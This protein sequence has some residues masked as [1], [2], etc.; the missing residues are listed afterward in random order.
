VQG[1]PTGEDHLPGKQVKL[2]E[3]G[4]ATEISNSSSAKPAG[5]FNCN[6]FCFKGLPEWRF[7]GSDAK[8]EDERPI[9][10]FNRLRTPRIGVS[11]EVLMTSNYQNLMDRTIIIEGNLHELV[12]GEEQRL[13]KE[14]QPI[15]RAQSVTLDM[16]NIERI[17]AAGIAVLI[18]LY[19]EARMSGHEFTITH[20]SHRVAEILELVG[21]D[22]ILLSQN[23]QTVIP[24]PQGENC[25]E[26]PAA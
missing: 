24:C 5:I 11:K 16:R 25:Y 21:L 18:S 20:A 12:R 10:R 13:V 8:V 22:R 17:D 9:P 15:V 4:R 7:G 2:F 23:T 3:S 26:M 19:G 14:L 6:C 1:I